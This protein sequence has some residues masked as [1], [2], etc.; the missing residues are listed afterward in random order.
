MN[1]IKEENIMLTSS[2]IGT[3]IAQA[4]K[5]KNLSQTDLANQMSVTAQAVGKWERGE[6]MPDII[7]F[8]RLATVLQVDLNYFSEGFASLPFQADPTVKAETRES[9][10][11][12]RNWDMSG[13][14]WKDSDFSGLKGL[15]ERF[16]SSNIQDC[17]FI[18][19]DL[20]TLKLKSNNL[21]G[22]DFSKSNLNNSHIGSSNIENCQFNDCSFCETIFTSSNIQK[23]NFNG[24][25]F[26][27]AI[28]KRC[29][30]EEVTTEKAKW[31]RTTF[32]STNF[33]NITF[34]SELI[35]CSFAN[36]KVYHTVFQNLTLR[37]CF[38]KNCNLKKLKFENCQA[39][40]ITLSFLKSNKA[41]VDEIE[42]I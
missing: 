10:D 5:L 41:E 26:T 23:S 30:L 20:S 14:N 29:N 40:N 36:I 42:L 3:K 15:G 4:R 22:S 17:K 25:D 8:N 37:N 19:S 12:G 39:D 9:K 28:F 35:D 34:D 18:G 38:F 31:V 27:D 21:Q 24:A 16:R 13:G 2:E 1:K 33:A 11:K 32:Q 7:T 6:S